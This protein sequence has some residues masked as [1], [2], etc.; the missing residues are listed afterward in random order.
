MALERYHGLPV[1]VTGGLGFIGSNVALRLEELGAVVT[2]VDSGLEGCGANAWNLSGSKARVLTADL[3][4]PDRYEDALR[5]ARVVFNLAGEISHIHSMQFPERDLQINTVSQ[6]RFLDR[7]RQVNRGVRVVYAGTRQIFG[8]PEYLP[9]DE[10]HPVR[11]VD[12]N[13]VHKYAAAMYHLMMS[14]LGELDAAVL[15]LT[16]VY[17]PRMSLNVAGQGFLGVFFRKA[18]LGEKLTVFGD[19]EQLRDPVYVDDVVRAFL[20]A[21]A[22]DRVPV[23]EMN[24]GGG[25]ALSLLGIGRAIAGEVELAPFPGHLQPI[26][27]GSYYTDSGLA[28]QMMGWKPEVDFT[29][30]VRRTLEYYRANFTRYLTPGEGPRMDLPEHA[31]V[32]RRLEFREVE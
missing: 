15:R 23:R 27:I 16:N 29:E 12:Y 7:L 3:S 19:G 17:G 14:G 31:G 22:L 30:G 20:L 4:D 8:K 18:L 13:G 21:G 6:L 2:V 10:K 26:D 11:P 28:W 5:E 24:I 32:K 9:V 1:L 25:E